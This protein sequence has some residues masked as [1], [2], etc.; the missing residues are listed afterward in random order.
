MRGAISACRGVEIK[1][2]GDSFF[3]IFGRATDALTAAVQAQRALA[4]REW[5]TGSPVAVRMGIHTGEVSRAEG[6]YVGLDIHRAARIAA[7]AHGGQVLLSSATSS[8]VAGALPDGVSLRDLGE[9]RLRDIEQ[10]EHLLQLVV[11][12][13]RADFPPPRAASTRFDLLPVELSS[14]VGREAELE[15]AGA[16]LTGTRLLT[17]TGPGG[18]GKTRLAIRVAALA[19][20]EFADGVAFVALAAIDDPALVMP[21]VRQAL[22]VTE[23]PGRPA[24]S[25][26][27]ERLA[28]REV[29][30]VLDNFEQVADAASQ[31]SQLLEAAAGLTLIVTSRL[32]LHLT[33]EQEFAVPPLG[34]PS[35]ADI[36]EDLI[37][38][39][40]T[41]AV[42][43]FVQRA[44]AVRPDFRLDASNARQVVD[45]CARLDGLPLAIELA[46][47]RIKVLPPAGLLARL[48]K[49]LDLLQSTAA[50]R[51]DRQRT[52]RGA[53]AWSYDLLDPA[54]QRLFRRLAVFVGGWR[55]DDAESIVRT[56]GETEL[57]M[58]DGVAALVDHSLIT[59]AGDRDEPRFAMLETIREYGQERLAAEQELAAATSAHAAH[60]ADLVADAE[61]KLTSGREWLD[62]LE[63]EQAN[64]RAALAW[65][66]E[67]DAQAALLT[68]GRLWRFWHLRGHLREG[69]AALR[70]L[71]ALPSAALP[72]A[73]RA[74]A[75]IGLAGLVYWQLDYASA[76]ASYEEAL[77]IARSIGERPLEVEV[78]YSLAFVRA[79]EQDWDGA[80]TDY[81]AAE[82]I[83]TEHGNELMAAWAQMGVGMVTTLRGEHAAALPLLRDSRDRFAAL[84]DAF[85]LRNIVSVESRALMQLGEL[86]ESRAT[87]RQVIEMASGQG[88]VTSLSAAILDTAGL[89]ALSG[90][91]ERSA[92]LTGAAERIVE[93]SGGQPPPQL[94]NR[95]EARPILAERLES[96]RLDELIAEGRRLTLDEAVES[97]LDD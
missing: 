20:D 48:E 2:E 75:L 35:S 55:L 84:G 23:Q 39:A 24:L 40:R 85:A 60:F 74:K 1:T 12:G 92:R 38:L 66:A 80:I 70:R 59:Q 5:P 50:D 72:T 97:A 31:L 87:N 95:V 54:E 79:I 89:L 76:R 37:G 10:P 58:L 4:E 6:E 33:G 11:D 36:A 81:R 61:A 21:T 82:Q 27:S 44:R 34:V 15:R 29:L 45:I 13:L 46:A 47:S 90:D 43:L 57:D 3:V 52:L 49:S 93:E 7:A 62:R 71:L 56:A 9:H 25:T 18:T 32:A 53:I 86:A 91:L 68:A 96:S 64:I 67:H 14:F 26:L 28:G 77:A 73:A 41:D 88:D 17:L 8:L 19:A 69:A 78:L 22:G 83:Y 30:L 42:A 51:T 63:L 16:L 65:L 94:I